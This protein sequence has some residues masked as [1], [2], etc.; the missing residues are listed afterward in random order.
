M[1]AGQRLLAGILL[2]AALPVMA[3][4]PP[5]RVKQGEGMVE[6]DNGLVL[7]RFTA[8]GHG[9]KQE[10]LAAKGSKWI[11]LAEGCR[12][13]ESSRA[14]SGLG[15]LYD[16]SIDPAHR[17][18]ASAV[19][20][21]IGPVQ[22]QGDWAEVVLRGGGEA[23]GIEQ[24]VKLER[25]KACVHLAVKATLVGQPPKLEYLLEPLLVAMTGRL[26]AVH[27][28][29]YEPTE[30]SVIGDRVFF[31]PLVSVQQGERFV[32]LVPDLDD[33][34]VHQVFARGARQHPDARSFAVAMD[35]D[36][37][38]LPAVL[39]LRLPDD[40]NA[41][42]LLAGGL[43][44]YI[45]HQH[46]WFQHRNRP[47]AMVR[48]LSTN[49]VQFGLDLLLS[50]DAPQGQGYRMA[51]QHLWQRFGR[52]HFYQP[53]PQVMPTAEYARVCYPAN[54]VYQGYE[55]V[56]DQLRHREVPDR[57]DMTCWQQW[58]VEGRMV[59]GLRLHA[60]QWYDFIANL[61]WWNN[62]CDAT[63]LFYWGTR[64]RNV[65][66]VN[67]A[68]QMIDL[69][70]SAPQ[71]RGIFPAVYD[72]KRHGW[73][74]SLWSPP[75]EGYDPARRVAYWDWKSGGAYQTAAASVTAGY[76]LQYRRDC[77]ADPRLLPY[78]RAYGD[79]LL[80]RI[81]TN[82][83]VPGWFSA[84][85][86][87]LPSMR[88]NADGGA[89]AWVLSELYL[90][91]HE[92]KYLDG[93]KHIAKFL[94]TEVMPQ[95]RWADFEAFYS[96]AVK[97]ENFFDARTGQWPCNTMS[98][99][100]A[101]QG[102]LS[103]YEA[104]RDPRYLEAAMAVADFASLFQAVWAPPYVV[105]AYPFGGCSSQLGD[106]EWLDQRAHRFAD[107]LV[108]LGLLT[109]R[110]DLVERGIAAGRSCLVL[111]NL[112]RHLANGVY[113]HADF[114]LGL[115]PENIDH[116]GFPQR[117]LGSG[118]SWNTVG[119]LTGMAHILQRLGG[120]YVD[121]KH[122]RAVGVD[123]VKVVAFERQGKKLQLT[124]E[125]QLARLPMPFA[126]PYEVELRLAGLASGEYT[127]LINQQPPRR[128]QVR[129]S[130]DFSL[131]IDTQGL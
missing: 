124:L 75:Q 120:V 96:C 103:L 50:A 107:P 16:T 108:R 1:K 57:P 82:G 72:L 28:P 83:C 112:P 70:L 84:A 41:R 93:A 114:P 67:K 125:N 51:A 24:T 87:P 77:E 65:D 126:S 81:Q 105:T 68:R 18:V 116:E 10:Y 58:E 27:A 64:L 102:F 29:T 5:L 119:G 4:P 123:G 91:T 49:V 97:P 23:A 47:G 69:T 11:L 106:C 17:F 13:P 34:N 21:D 44:D 80:A 76:L 100:W 12:P 53:R 95:Q 111:A 3:E 2:A 88:W 38:T 127:L 54:F 130:G 8:V 40:A 39:D 128:I 86:Q 30:D 15:A 92:R 63:G 104:A 61:G 22:N 9:L 99:S 115:G 26:D 101:L 52:A 36:K 85:L 121:F 32:G 20:R 129:R 55:V 37:T 89:H 74:R 90:A 110:Q 48:E 46:V 7:A 109:G 56:K 60:P 42:P 25:G 71:D 131:A 14:N 113:E 59:G 43:M 35:P 78:V 79:F 66:W 122:R 19:L 62:A 6:L 73:L 118:P 33:L 94:M 45:V 98:M 117:P 31:S